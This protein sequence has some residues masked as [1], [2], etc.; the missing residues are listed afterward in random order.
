MPK[1]PHGVS[2]ADAVR[3]LERLGFTVVRQRGSHIVMRRGESGCIIRITARSRPA[4]SLAS[5]AKQA[6]P[7]RNS[8]PNS[9]PKWAHNRC[10][11]HAPQSLASTKVKMQLHPAR[12]RLSFRSF[13]PFSSLRCNVLSDCYQQE[14]L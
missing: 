14:R 3:A 1:L 12:T 7:L 13:R 5:S 8:L 6:F 2:G 4:L 9:E 10:S 11:K